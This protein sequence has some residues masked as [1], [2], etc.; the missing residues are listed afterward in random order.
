MEQAIGQ[1]LAPA[2]AV[3]LSPFPVVAVILVLGAP[4]GRSSGA[5]FAL[6]WMTGLTVISSIVAVLADGAEDPES[7]AATGVAWSELLLGIAL[8]V[9]AWRKWQG[10]PGPGDVPD[11]PGWMA[12]ASSITPP[13]ALVLGLALSGANPKNVALTVAAAASVA[14]AG[15]D[16]AGSVV[17][18]LTFVLV[19]S[20]SVLGPVV[21]S[22]VRGERAAASLASV[23]DFMVTNQAVIVM[24][25]LL[26]FGVKLVGD[27]VA[28]LGR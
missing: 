7:A 26:V 28:D 2:A 17:A 8:L 14:E 24:V 4:K 15:V 6:G 20:A 25:V 5:T 12:R 13:G 3:A 21:F 19:G 22:T 10:R 27:G 11:L 9:L 18:V 1:V 23:K 16:G